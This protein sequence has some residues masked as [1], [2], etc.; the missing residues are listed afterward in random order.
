M[1]DNKLSCEDPNQ[2]GQN[3][4]NSQPVSLPSGSDVNEQQRPEGHVH[5]IGQ[6][7]PGE[8]HAAAPQPLPDGA[9]AIQTGAGTVQFVQ[10]DQLNR[11]DTLTP[12]VTP[13]KWIHNADVQPPQPIPP[14]GNPVVE[15]NSIMPPQSIPPPGNPVLEG[16]PIMPPPPGVPGNLLPPGQPPLFH[17]GLVPTSQLAAPGLGH[18]SPNLPH[19]VTSPGVPPTSVY[20]PPVV[21]MPGTMATMANIHQGNP[22]GNPIPNHPPGFPA[23][24]HAGLHQVLPPFQ[25]SFPPGSPG[26]NNHS[27]I[28]RG[29]ENPNLVRSLP[30]PPSQN[31]FFLPSK[32][33]FSPYGRIGQVFFRVLSPL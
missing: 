33:V 19:M 22:M 12:C 16:N 3:Q 26:L 4:E 23:P 7:Q 24:T 25:Q 5:S 29:F 21:P 20:H 27:Q 14:P 1:S 9:G 31:D 10:D 6:P 30:M 32:I 11:E 18:L 13:G 17:G 8:L 2:E 28:N 15:G